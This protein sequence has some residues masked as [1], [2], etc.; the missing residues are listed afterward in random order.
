MVPLAGFYGSLESHGSRFGN[1][2][3]TMLISVVKIEI[4]VKEL[5][6]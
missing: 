1:H 6:V 3:I 5:P 2:W 4:Y